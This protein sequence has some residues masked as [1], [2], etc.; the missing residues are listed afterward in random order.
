MGGGDSK[1]LDIATLAY[2]HSECAERDQWKHFLEYV[3]RQP[4]DLKFVR[5]ADGSSY[6][7]V[8]KIKTD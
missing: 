7:I 5:D 1:T 3:R 2:V 6:R 8:A 4:L